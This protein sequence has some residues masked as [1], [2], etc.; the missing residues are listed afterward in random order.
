MN[1]CYGAHV[2]LPIV[3]IYTQLYIS[4]VFFVPILILTESYIL[5]LCGCCRNIELLD[6]L[7]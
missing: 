3:T 7:G 2:N 4:L 6:A 1:I 5:N